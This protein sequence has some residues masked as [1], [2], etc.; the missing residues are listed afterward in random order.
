MIRVAVVDDHAAV[1]ASFAGFLDALDE[2]EIV[3]EAANGIEAIDV[4][5]AGGVDAFVMDVRMPVMDGIEAAR[6]IKSIA[7]ATRVVLITAYEHDEL[8]EAAAVAGADDVVFKGVSG[9]VLA[10]SVLAERE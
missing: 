1:R 6:V 7:P 10:A 3:A 5:R 4:C 2:I 8:R 9:A